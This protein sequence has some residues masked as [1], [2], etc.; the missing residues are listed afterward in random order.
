M[1]SYTPSL[2]QVK[3]Q[4][5][6]RTGT[7]VRAARP[8]SNPYL[9]GIALGIVLF[10]AFFFTGNGLGASGGMNR[11]VV[12]LQDAVAPAHVD[13]TP[14]LLD[15]AGGDKNP[16]DNWVV[17]LS[18]GTFVGG[19]ASGIW[20]GRVKLETNHGPRIT[21]Q[22]RWVAAFLGGTLMGYG[23][24]LHLWAGP[25]WRGGD[26]G[27]QL[28][29]YVRRLCGRLCPGLFCSAFVDIRSSTS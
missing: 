18:V 27:G 5:G 14:Y 7:Q 19:L 15:M 16:L 13:R 1:A 3:S 24:G 29:V 26:V 25:V 10:A 23:P 22:F 9:A 12:V 8:Y 4:T 20:N 6:A 2:K 28:V 17:F 11:M 21:P